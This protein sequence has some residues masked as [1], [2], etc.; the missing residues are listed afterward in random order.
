MTDGEKA[1]EIVDTLIDEYG[2]QP[3]VIKRI[4]RRGV[5]SIEERERKR[6]EVELTRKQQPLF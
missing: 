2:Y 3:E 5:E 6:K 1:K 4:L